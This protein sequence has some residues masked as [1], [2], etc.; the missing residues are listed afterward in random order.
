MGDE[1]ESVVEDAGTLACTIFVLFIPMCFNP[2]NVMPRSSRLVAGRFG[3]LAAQ[4]FER[5]NV[6]LPPRPEEQVTISRPSACCREFRGVACCT[7]SKR[8]LTFFCPSAD[9]YLASSLL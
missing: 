4:C 6:V 8:K 1:A 9:E 5:K 7:T 2:G 3:R